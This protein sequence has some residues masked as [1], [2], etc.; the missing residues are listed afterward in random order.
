M[1]MRTREETMRWAGIE[2]SAETNS[3]LHP[4]C[5]ICC[6]CCILL[7]LL[8]TACIRHCFI[9]LDDSAKRPI[10]RFYLHSCLYQTYTYIQRKRRRRRRRRRSSLGPYHSLIYKTSHCNSATQHCCIY[11]AKDSESRSRR[12]LVGRRISWT[13]NGHIQWPR[14]RADIC[15]L[16]F[17][18]CQPFSILAIS[19]EWQLLISS[20]DK[21]AK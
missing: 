10:L 2:I 5:C 7:Y 16:P 14:S 4:H 20:C 18:I 21:T 3:L 19:Y 6:I 8:C 11:V 17:A 13:V 15:H 1:F 12:G 9:A